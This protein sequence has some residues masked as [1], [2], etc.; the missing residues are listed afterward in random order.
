MPPELQA[1]AVGFPVMLLHAGVTLGL[2]A[3]GLALY[4]MLTPHREIALVREGNV[5][6]AVS[7]GGVFVGLALPLAAAMG[8]SRSLI[9]VA[10]WGAATT[11]VQLL[12]LRLTDFVLPGLSRR[13]AGGE[14]AAAVLLAS[15]KL[16]TGL[17]L[18]AAAR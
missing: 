1:F 14:V 18:A 13:I 12:V 10:I 7:L 3:L 16:A 11:V 15:A 5:A 17:V 8:A 6:A 4:V 9:D 2:L